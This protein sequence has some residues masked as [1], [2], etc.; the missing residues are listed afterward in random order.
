[1]TTYT[2]VSTPTIVRYENKDHYVMSIDPQAFTATLVSVN[3]R[4]WTEVLTAEDFQRLTVLEDPMSLSVER[5][6]E[7]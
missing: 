4:R 5:V 1:M 2:T 3:D 6:S 7:R